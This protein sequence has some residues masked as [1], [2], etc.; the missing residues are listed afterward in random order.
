MGPRT[1]RTHPDAFA[2]VWGQIKLQLD[3]DPSRAATETFAELQHR[4]PGKFSNGQLRTLQRRFQQR[5]REILYLSQSPQSAWLTVPP[6]LHE[7][8]E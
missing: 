3:I 6:Q 2:E 5:R 4:Y 8:G 7:R 1:W